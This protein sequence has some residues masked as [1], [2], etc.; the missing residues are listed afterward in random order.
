MPDK[1]FDIKI[2]ISVSIPILGDKSITLVQPP[3]NFRFEKIYLENY[4]YKDRITDNRGQILPEYRFAVNNDDDQAYIIISSMSTFTSGETF[5]F[6]ATA[7]P[8]I[9]GKPVYQLEI[10]ALYQ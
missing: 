10:I 4:K 8:S 7:V 1:L 2:N 3:N 5:D 9:Y 6:E